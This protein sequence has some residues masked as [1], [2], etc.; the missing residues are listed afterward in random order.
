[1]KERVR[2][3]AVFSFSRPDWRSSE[4]LRK[5]EAQAQ[6]QATKTTQAASEAADV[7]SEPSN[8]QDAAAAAVATRGTYP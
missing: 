1:M 3:E 7:T 6:S 5:V 2:G 4:E 8:N